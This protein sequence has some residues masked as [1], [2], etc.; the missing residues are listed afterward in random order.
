M[1]ENEGALTTKGEQLN[2]ENLLV[3]LSQQLLLA[4]RQGQ[5][6]GA[7][8]LQLQ[9]LPEQ[10][11][12]TLSEEEKKAFWI[13]LYN[14]FTQ[15]WLRSNPSMKKLHH[16][17]FTRHQILIAGHRLSLDDMEHGLLRRSQTKWGLGYIGKPFP[18]SKEKAWRVAVLDPRIHFALNCGARSC[19]PV[20]VYSSQQIDR[21]LTLAT[22]NFLETEVVQNQNFIQLP[23]LLHWFRGDFG[24]RKGIRHLLQ[25]HG[26]QSID[27][28]TCLR[29][30]PF[31]WRLM[32]GK[33]S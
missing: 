15:F 16:H 33:F 4:V 6:T 14:A 22:N 18:S 30:Q 1:M 20:A 10:T 8:L 11:V 21:Q 5:E 24:G 12:A 25:Q 23:A 9:S 13:N 31:D 19:P 26:F 32:P 3:H 17:F 28:A 2:E 7:L 27:A 29:F